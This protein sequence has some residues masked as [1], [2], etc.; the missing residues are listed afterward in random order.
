MLKNNLVLCKR[1]Y[2]LSLYLVSPKY[3]NFGER[4]GGVVV[5][6]SLTKIP[7]GSYSKQNNI[8]SQY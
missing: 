4:E 8:I 1:S 6:I 5:G 3:C 2:R 7:I